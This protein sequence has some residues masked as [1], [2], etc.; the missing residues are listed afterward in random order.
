[1]KAV[2]FGDTHGKFEALSFA[3]KRWEDADVYFQL[4]D[5]GYWPRWKNYGIEKINTRGKK[6]YF[7]DGNH[8]DHEELRKLIPEVDSLSDLK[9][10]E[11]YENIFYIPRG[12][13]FSIDG[14]NTR[15]L[16]VGGAMST[17]GMY[18][19][20]GYDYFAETERPTFMEMKRILDESDRGADILLSHTIPDFSFD[21][22]GSKYDNDKTTDGT[23]EFLTEVVKA[24]Q[25]K[26]V[27]AGH[28]HLRKE[29]DYCNVEVN[30]LANIEQG[31]M[32]LLWKEVN[33]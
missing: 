4:G 33:I 28:W 15:I 26:K 16:G 19:T 25:V 29:F 7:V 1:M 9:P 21:Y 2:F 12:C 3:I 30:V 11:I 17:D 31:K 13:V 32:S 10:I 22:L 27:F 8:E 14:S 23:C 6:L 24:Y 18:R 20:E 5:F